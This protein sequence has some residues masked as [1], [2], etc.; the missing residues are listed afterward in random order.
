MPKFGK[1]SL[2]CIDTC[3]PDLQQLL[4]EVIKK[5]DISVRWGWRGEKDQNG[6]VAAGTSRTRW[7]N[8]K[9]NNVDDDGNP[10]SLAFD[11]YPYPVPP[12]TAAG[13][14]R[15]CWVSGY[16]KATADRMGIKLRQGIDWD[17][18][19]DFSDQRLNDLVHHELLR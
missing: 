12:R 16:I 7:P 13:L 5:V 6:F 1:R 9:H 10:E 15:H 8:S 14:R 19:G 3:H 4:H 17:G 2:L 18:D 11:A